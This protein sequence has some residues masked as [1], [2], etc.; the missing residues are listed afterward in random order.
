MGAGVR[1]VS[2]ALAEAFV[3][4]L[5][6][7]SGIFERL[8]SYWIEHKIPMIHKIVLFEQPIH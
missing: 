3:C 1:V 6:W 7:C 2:Y 5:G 4:L 8:V